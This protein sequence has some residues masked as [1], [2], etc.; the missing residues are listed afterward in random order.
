MINTVVNLCIN[1]LKTWRQHLKFGINKMFTIVKIQTNPNH[2]PCYQ[3]FAQDPETMPI[4]L[5][6]SIAHGYGE[7]GLSSL[8][9]IAAA[10]K[11][12]DALPLVGEMRLHSVGN[13]ETVRRMEDGGFAYFSIYGGHFYQLYPVSPG[14]VLHHLI[15][16]AEWPRKQYEFPGIAGFQQDSSSGV[17]YGGSVND[18]RGY[19]FDYRVA[20]DGRE[21]NLHVCRTY[22]DVYRLSD[23]QASEAIKKY[24]GI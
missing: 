16:A 1:S 5:R 13:T 18:P 14:E 22:R 17:F 7:E 9:E 24:F 10:K 15:K 21:F 6:N 8:E 20:P 2:S 11:R 23:K 19:T 12:F 3:L 4:H